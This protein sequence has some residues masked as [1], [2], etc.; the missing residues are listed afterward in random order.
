[1]PE[2]TASTGKGSMKN[3]IQAPKE[4]VPRH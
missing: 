2:A 3:V 1:M 4:V